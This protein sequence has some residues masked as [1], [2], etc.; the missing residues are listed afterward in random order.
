MA[1]HGLKQ[2][3]NGLQVI[4]MCEVPSNVILAEEFLDILDG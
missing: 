3:E 1:K 4:G 2:H